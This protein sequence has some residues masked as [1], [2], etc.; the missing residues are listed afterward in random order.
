ML[1]VE[2]HHVYAPPFGGCG[3]DSHQ[4]IAFALYQ[5]SCLNHGLETEDQAQIQD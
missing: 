3:Y 4:P 5:A 1:R 2:K